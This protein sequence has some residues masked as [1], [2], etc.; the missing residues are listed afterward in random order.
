VCRA[1]FLLSLAEGQVSDTA[2]STKKQANPARYWRNV[3]ALAS[4]QPE[5]TAC[6]FAEALDINGA[7]KVFILGR[8]LDKLE[9]VASAAVGHWGKPI[10]PQK[11]HLCSKT[12]QSFPFDAT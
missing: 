7:K 3:C 8:R 9:E 12:S 1:W 5:L 6:R 11:A 2:N 10:I 4:A